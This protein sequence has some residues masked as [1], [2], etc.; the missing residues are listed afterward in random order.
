MV[1]REKVIN[2]L[3]DIVKNDWIW[4]L[5]DYYALTMKRALVLLKEQPEI[6]RCQDCVFR[7]PRDGMCEH[8]LQIRDPD[9]FCADGIRRDDDG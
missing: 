3:Q 5:A 9:W 1:D 8:V 2:D 6:V 7:D 4:Q